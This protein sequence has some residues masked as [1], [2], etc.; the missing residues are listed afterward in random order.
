[1]QYSYPNKNYGEIFWLVTV[2]DPEGVPWVPSLF[3][4]AAFDNILC[5]NV[6]TYTL[7]S[8]WSYALQ[9]QSSKIALVSTQFPV[10]R[11]QRVRSLRARIMSQASERIRFYSCIALSADRGWR[12]AISMRALIF[13]R[14]TRI[15]SCFAAFAGR[16]GVTLLLNSAGFKHK[17]KF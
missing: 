10:S 13:L 7:C 9:L 8:H 6:L 15:T 4:R 2:A 12:Y 16:N 3:W 5:A 11:I 14:L 1:M 17:N